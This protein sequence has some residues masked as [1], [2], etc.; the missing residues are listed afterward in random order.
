MAIIR[1][2]SQTHTCGLKDKV[3]NGLKT[4]DNSQDQKYLVN[5]CQ[6]RKQCTHQLPQDISK[7]AKEVAKSSVIS[8]NRRMDKETFDLLKE[9]EFEATDRL[10]ATTGKIVVDDKEA[11]E[12]IESMI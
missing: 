5:A 10:A 4:L 3:T 6:E 8:T 7:N 1:D 12:I 9:L 11:K 2:R